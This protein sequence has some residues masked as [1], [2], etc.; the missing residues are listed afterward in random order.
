VPGV[1]VVPEPHVS[2]RPKGP[3]PMNVTRREGVPQVRARVG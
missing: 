3:M 1:P 2:L